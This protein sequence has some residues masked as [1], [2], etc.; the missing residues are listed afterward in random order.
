MGGKSWAG[1]KHRTKSPPYG[2][3]GIGSRRCLIMIEEADQGEQ[4]H[5]LNEP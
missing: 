4:G 3:L 1:I 2:G 5:F